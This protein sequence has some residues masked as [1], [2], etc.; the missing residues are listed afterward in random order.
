MKRLLVVGLVMATTV[1]WLRVMDVSAEAFA[2]VGFSAAAMGRGDAVIASV[3]DASAMW[4]N[5][6][7]AAFLEGH[8]LQINIDNIYPFAE[9]KPRSNNPFSTQ[10][11]KNERGLSQLGTLFYTYKPANLMD[12]RWTF[13]LGVNT[14]I[15]LSVFYPRSAAASPIAYKT[16]IAAFI[17]NLNAAFKINDNLAVA[18][19]IMILTLEGE[20]LT[21]N[22]RAAPLGLTDPV[23]GDVNLIFDRSTSLGANA[24]I[25]YKLN[26][27]NTLGFTFRS[28]LRTKTDATAE[29]TG[30]LGPYSFLN[31]TYKLKT[32]IH[33]LVDQYSIGWA[34]QYSDKLLAEI[35]GIWRNWND[36]KMLP[37][38][39]QGNT[40]AE[41]ALLPDG[42]HV[43]YNWKNG[44]IIAIGTKYDVSERWNY[45]LGYQYH[46]DPVPEYYTVAMMPDTPQHAISGGLNFNLGNFT[47]SPSFLYGTN[48]KKDIT[49]PGRYQASSNIDGEWDIQV[50]HFNFGVSYKF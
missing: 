1:M 8:N 7:R 5:P 47:L 36:N 49:A 21:V 23:N 13:G 11:Y 32:N 25:S 10:S 12:G 27:K 20:L 35:S 33:Y 40:P 41:L 2:N 43:K 19:G 34:H 42:T 31:G 16:S 24:A 39:R 9:H 44:G 28:Q 45:T 22:N 30:F 50:Y 14:P 17:Y 4:Y 29:V 48:G 3:D 38:N 26:E 46:I 15:G 37:Y 6:A 18:A